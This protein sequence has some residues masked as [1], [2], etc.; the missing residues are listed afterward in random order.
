M[1]AF[2]RRPPQDMPGFAL[3]GHLEKRL[4]A[5]SK[6]RR[7]QVAKGRMHPDAARRLDAI[8]AEILNRLRASDGVVTKAA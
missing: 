2:D 3:A 5:D 7:T 4:A 8:D 1:S 6:W